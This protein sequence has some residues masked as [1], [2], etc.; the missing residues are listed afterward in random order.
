[1]QPYRGRGY[2]GQL[3][4]DE[5]CCSSPVS[6]AGVSIMSYICHAAVL[7]DR[8]LGGQLALEKIYA[9]GPYILSALKLVSAAF[10][11]GSFL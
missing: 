10:D 11:F 2:G 8:G 7:T 9:C 3:I 6:P 5:N 4:P 1:M